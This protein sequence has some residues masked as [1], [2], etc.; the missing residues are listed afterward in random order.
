MPF[1][2]FEALSW[3]LHSTRL[4]IFHTNNKI[5][6][7]TSRF[8]CDWEDAPR[9]HI[10]LLSGNEAKLKPF[11]MWTSLWLSFQKKVIEL[12]MLE[13]HVAPRRCRIEFVISSMFLPWKHHEGIKE[14]TWRLK[15]TAVRSSELIQSTWRMPLQRIAN[16]NEHEQH[17]NSSAQV[18][19]YF[20]PWPLKLSARD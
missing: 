8:V 7:C 9:F 1:L 2:F 12:L 18:L 16:I 4:A 10:V 13:R 17:L 14:W 11:K 3:V 19:L 5:Q 15:T 20:T 6:G